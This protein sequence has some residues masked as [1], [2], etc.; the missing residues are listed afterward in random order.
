MRRDF[1]SVKVSEKKGELG[2]PAL[3]TT[4]TMYVQ[5]IV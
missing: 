5:V 3:N 4:T 2:E 1:Y